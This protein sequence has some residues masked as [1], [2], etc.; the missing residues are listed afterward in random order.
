MGILQRNFYSRATP[1]VA[2]D[3]LGKILIHETK[4]GLTSGKIVETEAYLGEHDPASRA[5]RGRRT[6]ISDLMWGLPGRAFIYMVHGNWLLNIVTERKGKAGAVLI[7]AVEPL[8]GINLMRRRRR[9]KQMKALAS[10]PGKLTQALGITQHDQGVDVTSPSSH[11]RIEE[12]GE[13]EFKVGKS[14]RV[15]VTRDLRRKLRFFILGNE[16]VSK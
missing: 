6:K 15:G 2:K 4:E 12:Y 1:S 14:H 5:Y 3:L 10:G 9:V 8:Y 13:E 11:L 7:R 16:F